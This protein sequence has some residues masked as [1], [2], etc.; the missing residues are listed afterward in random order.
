MR[1]SSYPG[2]LVLDPFCGCGTTVAAADAL[3]RRRIGIDIDSHAIKVMI[4]RLGDRT[5]PT[6]GHPSRLPLRQAPLP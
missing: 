4:Q 5:I 3:G 1:A 2:D 6:C